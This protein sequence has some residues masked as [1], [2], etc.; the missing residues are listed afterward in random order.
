MKK[1]LLIIL[2]LPLFSFA[3]LSTQEKITIENYGFEFC[4]CINKVINTLDPKAVE[5]IYIMAEKSQ[6]EAIKKIE[7][8]I[9]SVSEE[10]SKKLYSSFDEMNSQEFQE[11][12]GKCAVREGMSDELANAINNGKGPSNDYLIDY[13]KSNNNCLMTNYLMTLGSSTDDN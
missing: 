10:K 12:I 7:E 4:N 5:F 13:L 8:Y 1:V 9:N 3:Q 11:K 6:D 2:L